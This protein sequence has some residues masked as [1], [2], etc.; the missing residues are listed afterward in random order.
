MR[1]AAIEN[2]PAHLRRLARGHPERAD[3]GQPAE[4]LIGDQGIAL[5]LGAVDVSAHLAQADEELLAAGLVL[6]G[7]PRVWM[8]EVE[9]EDRQVQALA[10]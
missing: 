3:V 5:D 9:V 10:Q 2:L 1:E 8:D 4:D 6:R 7:R